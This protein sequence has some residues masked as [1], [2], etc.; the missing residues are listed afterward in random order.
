MRV[1][2]SANLL[3]PLCRIARLHPCRSHSTF[4]FNAPQVWEDCQQKAKQSMWERWKLEVWPT[5]GSWA[6]PGAL[7]LYSVIEPGAMR[8]RRSWNRSMMGTR[9]HLR[10]RDWKR[11]WLSK[12]WISP[13]MRAKG[14]GDQLWVAPC[15]QPRL[16]LRWCRCG[17]P[18]R[19]SHST[20]RKACERGGSIGEGGWKGELGTN[21][22]IKQQKEQRNCVW[23]CDLSQLGWK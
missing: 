9:S 12:G 8:L 1:M 16:M 17:C 19:T 4:E 22:T 6:G 23:W 18:K 5:A 3:S 21:Q 15:I 11:R 7:G 20:S 10:N 14:R 13:W 2:C